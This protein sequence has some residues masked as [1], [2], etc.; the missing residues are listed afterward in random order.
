MA[1]VIANRRRGRLVTIEDVLDRSSAISRTARRRG[2]Q[3]HQAAAEWRLLI[4]AL[5]PIEN[6]NDF[7][8]SDFSDDEFD[9][10]AAGHERVRHLPKRNEPQKS[11]WRS[12]AERRRRRVHLLRLTP[13]SR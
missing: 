13:I 12:R 5:T 3:L 9:T 2:R 1:I 6:F 10:V 11:C 8:A 4:K 7:F